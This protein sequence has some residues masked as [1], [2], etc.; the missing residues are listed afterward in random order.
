M[1]EVTQRELLETMPTWYEVG[2][3]WK[4]DLSM[5]AGLFSVYGGAAE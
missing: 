5:A 4:R 1:A 2:L 3:I